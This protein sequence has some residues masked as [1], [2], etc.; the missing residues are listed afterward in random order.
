MFSFI[1]LFEQP[2]ILR[3]SEPTNEVHYEP[4]NRAKKRQMRTAHRIYN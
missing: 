3:N 4:H 2:Y 1:H